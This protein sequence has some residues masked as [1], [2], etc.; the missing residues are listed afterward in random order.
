MLRSASRV[1]FTLAALFVSLP[2]FAQPTHPPATDPPNPAPANDSSGDTPK[3]GEPG[4]DEPKSDEPKGDASKKEPAKGEGPTKASDAKSSEADAAAAKSDAKPTDKDG[5]TSLK[6]DSPHV[7]SFEFGSYGRVVAGLDGKGGRARD[8][9]IVAHGSRLDESNYVEL[10]LRR[11][12]VWEKTGAS[13]KIVATLA[14]ANPIFHYTGNFDIKL[15]VRNLYIEEMD[16]A[17]KG[18]SVWAGS[19]MVRGDDIYLLDFWPL[20]NL[21]TIG[22]GVG[23]RHP[24]G[25]SAQLHFGVSQPTTPFYIQSV[26]RPAPLDQYGSTP[27]EI[28]NRQRMIGSFRV[29]HNQRIGG[30]KDGPGPGIKAVLYGELHA[31][32]KGQRETSQPRVYE[33]LPSDGGFVLGGQ[34]GAYTG[35]RDTHVNIF[36]RYATG[37]AAYGQFATPGQLNTN[38]TTDGAHELVIAAGGN[39][40]VGLFGVMAGAYF[41]SFRDASPALDYEDVDEGIAIVRPTVFFGEYGGLSVE[42]SYQIAQRGVISPDPVDPTAA[43]KGPRM[44]SAF[45]FGVIPFVSPA[46]RGDYT[47]PHIRLIYAV[48]ARNDVARDLY[49]QDDVFHRRSIDHFIGLGAEWWFNSSTYGF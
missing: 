1:A 32:P 12:D 11:E 28:L 14:V 17:L 33:D 34:V 6:K 37:L 29:S 26:D 40:E 38:R 45:R 39:A 23:Y 2:A 7:G 8:A 13:T 48:T 36:A 42:G 5:K 47:R 25:T 41:R 30:P 16:L 10:E 20:D 15:A 46:G 24:I 31:L 35:E 3:S 19:R 27:V 9:D 22:A 43:P 49:P 21:N 4:K 18:L 44:A